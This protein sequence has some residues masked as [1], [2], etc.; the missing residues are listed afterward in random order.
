MD[1]F[2]AQLLN[3][4]ASGSIYALIVLG[5]NLLM[6]VKK[7]VHQCF[8]NIVVMAMAF[9]WITLNLTGNSLLLAIP[10][11]LL[12]GIVMTVATEPIFRP[13]AKRGADLE[14]IVLSLGI[15]IILTEIYSHYINQGQSIGFPPSLTSGNKVI[16]KGL[17]SISPVTLYTLIIGVIVVFL[18]M[19]FLY[20]HKEGKAI[21][22][23]A[24]NPY[25]AKQLGISAA[26]SGIIGFA[27]AGLLAGI[28]AVLLSMS[29]GYASAELGSTTAIKAIILM[30]FAGSG[31]LKGGLISALLMGAVEA[32]AFAF[33][34][35]RWTEAIFYGVIMVVILFK[36][37]GLFGTRT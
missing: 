30:L 4:L 1:I 21:R 23:V 33:L 13:L 15:G 36:P 3:G 9:G 25:I 14:T 31:N 2:L 27:I 11:M 29:L 24:Q 7:I 8:A 22:A 35:G 20:R 5:M 10:V 16:G 37:E 17:I 6:L 32:F 18:L 34:P 19:L 26:K 12:G 28:I